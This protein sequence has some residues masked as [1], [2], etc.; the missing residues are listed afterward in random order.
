MKRYF[1]MLAVMLFTVASWAQNT[2]YL[3]KKDFQSEKKKISE[4]IDAAKKTGIDAKKIAAKQVTLIDSLTKSL[5]ANE[6][7]LA[8]TNDSLQK[9]AARFNELEAR[10]SKS[11]INAQNSILVA[12]IVFSVLFLLLFALVF[13]L[14]RNSNE[15]IR[16][17]SEE[18]IRLG[19]TVKQDFIEMKKEQKKFADALSLKLHENSANL[20]ARFE[21][22]EEKQKVFASELKEVVDKVVKEQVIQKSKIDE[23]L[24]EVLSKA[25][26]EKTEH[27]SLHEKID[28][29]VKGLRSLHIK[30]MEEIKTKR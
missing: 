7:A 28:S 5:S 25:N 1:T 9:T 30:D 16:E 18:N 6:K 14:K 24:K 13:F 15:K 17:L 19:E 4:G 10:A 3:L 12:V 8:Q 2:D 22:Q 20:A 23:Q 11:S 27:K 21:Q 26:E 29:E